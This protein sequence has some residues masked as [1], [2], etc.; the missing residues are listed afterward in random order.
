MK[1]NFIRKPTPEELIPQD[2]FIVEKTIVLESEVFEGFIR[3]P[4]N[5]Y[6][7]IK[8]YL[9]LMYCDKEGIF[10]CLL[11]TS[12]KHDFGILVESEGYH[13]ARYAAFIPLIKNKTEN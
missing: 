11:V 7:F 8:E 10:H 5:D 12:D 3:D 4:L 2:E 1:V 9:D 13:Y 6:D